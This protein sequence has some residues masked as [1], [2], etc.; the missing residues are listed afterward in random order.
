MF[1][2]AIGVKLALEVLCFSGLS[3]FSDFFSPLLG[4]L[5]FQIALG[6]LGRKV[7]LG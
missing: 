4:V 7:L 1:Q 5:Q 3:A 2:L 6:S